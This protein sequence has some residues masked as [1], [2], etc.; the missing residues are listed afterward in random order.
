MPNSP[1]RPGHAVLPPAPQTWCPDPSGQAA[2]GRHNIPAGPH[3]ARVGAL[4]NERQAKKAKQ[5]HGETKV[6]L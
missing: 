5:L 2:S 4:P 6:Y 1:P 3:S